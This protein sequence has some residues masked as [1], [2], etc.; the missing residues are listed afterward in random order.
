MIER[1]DTS[2]QQQGSF[3]EDPKRML[4]KHFPSAEFHHPVG[5]SGGGVTPDMIP[6]ATDFPLVPRVDEYVLHEFKHN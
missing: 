4:P 3:L 1:R 5:F 6:T 2:F